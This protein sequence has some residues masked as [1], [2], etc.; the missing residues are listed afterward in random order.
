MTQTELLPKTEL[1]DANAVLNKLLADE[2]KAEKAVGTAE[3]KLDAI[4]ALIRRQQGVIRYL[5]RKQPFETAEEAV[6]NMQR[7]A[8]EAGFGVSLEV[9]GETVVLAEPPVPV[10]PETGEVVGLQSGE[11]TGNGEPEAPVVFVYYP[12]SP[13]SVRAEIGEHTTYGELVADYLS[14]ATE[15]GTVHVDAAVEDYRV[16]STHGATRPLNAAI[17]KTDYGREFRIKLALAS[18]GELVGRKE[19][20]A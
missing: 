13:G 7:T 14:E 6:R 5:G 12:G 17:V 2:E 18:D 11:E 9:D 19:A 15:T 1:D 10:D 20:V 3:E 16:V 8:E 4:D